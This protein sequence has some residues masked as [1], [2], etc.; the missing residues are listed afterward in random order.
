MIKIEKVNVFGLDEALAGNC[1]SYDRDKMPNHEEVKLLKKLTIAGP[2]HAKALRQIFVTMKITAPMY[3]WKEMDTYKVATVRNSSSTMHT[4]CKK[5][6]KPEDFSFDNSTETVNAYIEWMVQQLNS[7]RKIYLEGLVEDGNV[8]LEPK[9]KDIW[10]SII[11]MLPS[12]YNQTSVWTGNYETLAN[13]I[14]QREGHKLL[15]WNDFIETAK[16]L[17]K[18]DLIFARNNVRKEKNLL[19]MEYMKLGSIEEIKKIKEKLN[20]VYG[21]L[22]EAEK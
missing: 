15:E 12:S 18:S 21:T 6:F 9:D 20:S 10:R 7:M 2:S 22:D 11:Q 14:E 16:N 19:L 4:I 17:P 13:I 1:L 8:L 5:E 3:W